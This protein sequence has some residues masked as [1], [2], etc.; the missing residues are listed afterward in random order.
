[1]PRGLVAQVERVML[2]AKAQAGRGGFQVQVAPPGA[3]LAARGNIIGYRDA[4]RH[5]GMALVAVRA[6]SEDPRA[7]ET[8]ANEIAVKVI[9]DQV[10]GRG[11]LRARHFFGQVAARIGRRDVEL[12]YGV[13]K[14]VQL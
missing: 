11:D 8:E 4:Y 13:R 12:Q 6:I 10:A 3:A 9:A 5:A 14:V 7:P 2:G 1:M